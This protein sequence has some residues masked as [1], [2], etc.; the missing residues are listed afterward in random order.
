MAKKPKNR[1][2][3]NALLAVAI[4]AVCISLVYL[5]NAPSHSPT[6]A[7]TTTKEGG[8]YEYF[9]NGTPGGGVAGGV[10]GGGGNVGILSGGDGSPGNPYQITS[11]YTFIN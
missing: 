1:T 9:Y 8:V 5:G 10:P 6:G 2:A 11:F 3:R 7:A 4:A